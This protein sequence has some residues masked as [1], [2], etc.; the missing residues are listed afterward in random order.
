M[1]LGLRTAIYHVPDLARA[2]GWYAEAFGWA[3]IPTREPWGPAR[4]GWSR[5]GASPM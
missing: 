2:K 3:S 5:T 4:A 1:M